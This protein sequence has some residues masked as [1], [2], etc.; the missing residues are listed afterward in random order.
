[1]GVNLLPDT[2][3]VELGATVPDHDLSDGDMAL[4]HKRSKACPM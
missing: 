2:V 1:V 4:G 3:L